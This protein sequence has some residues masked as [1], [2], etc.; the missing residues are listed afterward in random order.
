MPKNKVQFQKGQSLPDFLKLYGTEQQCR[1]TLFTMRWPEGF[2]CPV[3]SHNEYSYITTRNLYQCNL[4]KYQASVTSGTIFDSTKLP[5]TTWFLAIYFIAQSKDGISSLNLSRTLGISA[6]ASLR[7][8]HKLQQVMKNRDDSVPLSGIIQMDDAY[9]G[10][11]RHD[12]KRGRGAS[13]KTPIVAAVS[14]NLKGR[15]ERMR[16]SVVAGFSSAEIKCWSSKYLDPY[17]IVITDGL[18]CFSAVER[19]VCGHEAIITGGGPASVELPEFKWVN[20]VIGNVKNS[21]R[22]T[23]HSVSQK[24]LPRYLAE[25]CYRFNRRF[26]LKN[27]THRLLHAAINSIPIPQHKLSLAEDWW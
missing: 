16:L 7:M 9:M 5:L 27:I 25:F 13:G 12:G 6:N 21:I 15:P 17:S 18:A 24:H 20:T 1:N 11:K 4:C 2:V 8:K 14:T 22:G 26:N 19:N 10:G 23:Y 3:C